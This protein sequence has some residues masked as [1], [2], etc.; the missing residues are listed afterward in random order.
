M[1]CSSPAF[2]DIHITDNNRGINNNAWHRVNA[3]VVAEEEQ[4][5]EDEEEEADD[6]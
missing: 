4:P 6:N 5:E 3:K 1:F 2:V